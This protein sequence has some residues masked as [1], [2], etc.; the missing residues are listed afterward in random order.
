MPGGTC[1]LSQKAAFS[2]ALDRFVV[3]PTSVQ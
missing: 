1:M 2:Y 3:K